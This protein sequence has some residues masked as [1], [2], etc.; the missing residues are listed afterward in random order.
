M[1]Q[2]DDLR[3]PT[4]LEAAGDVLE[5]GFGTG[6]NLPLYGPGV[7]SLVAVD[8][9]AHEGHGPTAERVARAPFPVERIGLGADGALPL[10]AARFDC[11]VSTWTLCSIPDLPAALA[12]VRR[13]LRPGGRFLFVEHG[14]APES[15]A[16]TARWQDR[17]NPVWRRIA[18]GCNM[19]RPID[20]MVEG[21]GFRLASLERF[22]HDG[23]AVLAQMFRG[24]AERTD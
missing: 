17:L 22:R 7:T 10:D 19:N 20:R 12:E 13:L 6:R 24:V 9:H 16:R 5:I 23:P 4:V 8:P 11:A 18:D 3:E 2:V 15:D 21:A 14:R 1:S